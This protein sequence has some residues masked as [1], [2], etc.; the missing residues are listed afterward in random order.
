VALTAE[1]WAIEPLE[2]AELRSSFFDD[3][4]R[5]PVGTATPDSAFL[6]A[7]LDTSWRAQ[8]ALSAGRERV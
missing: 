2:L 4:D 6:M 3:R 7:G 1:G 5:F 8:P